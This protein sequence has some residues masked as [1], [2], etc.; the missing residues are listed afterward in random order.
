MTAFRVVLWKG[1]NFVFNIKAKWNAAVLLDI[2]I[3]LMLWNLY[4]TILIFFQIVHSGIL[5][6]YVK[7]NVILV[8]SFVY[9]FTKL[10]QF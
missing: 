2:Y 1:Y 4:I 9:W 8:C 3:L 10:L 7:V 5:M 6:T